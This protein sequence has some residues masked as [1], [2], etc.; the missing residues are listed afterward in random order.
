MPLTH[1]MELSRSAVQTGLV[2]LLQSSLVLLLGLCLGTAL[3]QRGPLAQSAAYRAVLVAV[4]CTALCSLTFSPHLHPV[5]RVSLPE[6]P[7]QIVV[8]H[9]NAPARSGEVAAAM[10]EKRSSPAAFAPPPS[11][12]QKPSVVIPSDA[13]PPL[14]WTSRLYIAAAVLW[15]AGSLV[16][17][18]AIALGQWTLRRLQRRST[19]LEAGPAL[20]LLRTIADTRRKQRLSVR[21]S[22]AVR[23]P[24]LA[25]IRGPVIYLPDS[26]ATD[27]DAAELQAI[28]AHEA[29][30]Q[31][32]HDVAWRLSARLLCALLWPQP[33]LWI[34]VRRMELAAEEACDVLAVT[35]GCPPRAYADCLLSLTERLLPSRAE[36]HLG[37]GVVPFR[38]QVGRRIQQILSNSPRPH[39]ISRALRVGIVVTAGAAVALGLLVNAA[40]RKTTP[41]TPAGRAEKASA[42]AAPEGYLSQFVGAKRW[43]GD[44]QPI[45]I[46]PTFDKT[47][48]YPSLLTEA[49]KALIRQCKADAVVSTEYASGG[50]AVHDRTVLESILAR[51][52]HFFYA[53]YLMGVWYKKSHDAR[54]AQIWTDRAVQ[55]APAILAGRVQFADGRPVNGYTFTPSVSLYQS[56][57]FMDNHEGY[58]DPQNLQY[59]A[60]VTDAHGCYYLPVFR[61]VYDQPRLGNDLGV[62]AERHGP[63]RHA[64]GRHVA[65]DGAGRAAPVHGDRPRR[66]SAA[67]DRAALPHGRFAVPA[68]QSETGPPAASFPIRPVRD[69]AALPRR[70]PVRGKLNRSHLGAEREPQ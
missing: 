68:R 52:P 57:N 22:P 26:Y 48:L 20:A 9:E 7:R 5:W 19:P 65:A 53:E 69:M 41:N 46:L 45:Q 44:I 6:T 1:I 29:A 38:S 35:Q 67:D 61:A 49:D 59:P 50:P 11:A 10:P 33:L 2:V 62:A 37:L 17:L 3:R 18:V 43:G 39:R 15:G 28:V 8:V 64:H 13:P 24:F 47:V 27:F 21:T 58:D 63:P 25:G 36:R 56:A 12:D 66:R 30:H 4:V 31:E 51:R 60:V 34:L 40:S 70:R 32:R 42:W 14:P 55:D 16:L 23:S 54:G